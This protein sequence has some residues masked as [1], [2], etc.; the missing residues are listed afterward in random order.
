MFIVNRFIPF[1]GFTAINLF[2]LIFVRRGQKFTATDLQHERIH[3]R[4][5]LELLILP[6]YVIY[7]IEWL[8]R[9]L[10]TH[11][12]IRAY[13]R[14]SFEREAYAHQSDS[15]YLRHRPA[16]AWLHYLIGGERV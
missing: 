13:L 11:H 3:T 8:L 14:I 12:V 9:L 1:A 5:M 15:N 16:Y 4:Q 7:L 6:F 10:Q 2:G